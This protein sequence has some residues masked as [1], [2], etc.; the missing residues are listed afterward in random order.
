MTLSREYLEI[1][2]SMIL[3]NAAEVYASVASK[4]LEISVAIRKKFGQDIP[5]Y[6]N[7]EIPATE[8][9]AASQ[10][11][12]LLEVRSEWIIPI[13]DVKC[14]YPKY[15]S[16]IAEI[17][18][19]A[20]LYGRGL[21]D[22]DSVQE[23]LGVTSPS[24]MRAKIFA[25]RWYDQNPQGQMQVAALAAKLRGDEAEATRLEL[26]AGGQI[27]EEGFPVGALDEQAALAEQQGQGN[28]VNP[29]GAL[30]APPGPP[31]AI[32]PGATAPGQAPQGGAP[33]SNPQGGSPGLPGGQNTAQ[34]VLAGIVGGAE[35]QGPRNA[36]AMGAAKMG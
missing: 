19:A 6:D 3:D 27:T 26:L 24:T 13:Y 32:G 36:A 17:Q 9:T 18:Q 5:V 33:A 1:A 30:N 16:N 12:K 29:P 4:I 22:F 14:E 35:G 20:D 8:T 31:G 34:S 2:N 23:K 10:Q 15:P 25:D 28:G 7:I 21:T 11:H